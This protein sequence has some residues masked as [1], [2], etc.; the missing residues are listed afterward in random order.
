MARGVVDRWLHQSVSQPGHSAR[1]VAKWRLVEHSLHVLLRRPTASVLHPLSS[2]SSSSSDGPILGTQATT[3]AAKE[4]KLRLF[5][6]N[7]QRGSRAWSVKSWCIFPCRLENFALRKYIRSFS[8]HFCN[9][10]RKRKF[11]GNTFSYCK[12]VHVKQTYAKLV[13]KS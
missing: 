12:E 5:K 8:F 9:I 7:G 4:K 13:V 2:A 11:H 3:V 6:F 10:F 1:P